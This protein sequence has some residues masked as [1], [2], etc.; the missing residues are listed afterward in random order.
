[1]SF[2]YRYFSKKFLALG[3][4]RVPF[5]GHVRVVYHSALQHWCEERIEFKDWVYILNDSDLE[6][7]YWFKH[8]RDAVMFALRWL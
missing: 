8:E 1:M 2:Q 3:W 7:E 4:H 5:R 6:S